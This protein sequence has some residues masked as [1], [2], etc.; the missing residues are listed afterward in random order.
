M[1]VQIHI[2]PRDIFS[3]DVEPTETVLSLKQKIAHIKGIPLHP[4]YLL[5]KGKQM[6]DERTLGRYK[7]EED[8]IIF[9]LFRLRR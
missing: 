3:V 1:R 6:Q 2:L 7:I 9:L 5:R 8:Q 4:Q